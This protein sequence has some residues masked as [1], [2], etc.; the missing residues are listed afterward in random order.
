MNPSQY[1]IR[2]ELTDYILMNDVMLIFKS[3]WFA[4]Y[5]ATGTNQSIAFYQAFSLRI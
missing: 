2:A 4:L 5:S 3:D 1:N